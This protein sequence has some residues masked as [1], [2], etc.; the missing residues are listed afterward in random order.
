MKP[1]MV[2]CV[3]TYLTVAACDAARRLR[4]GANTPGSLHDLNTMGELGSAQ[5]E[6][7]QQALLRTGSRAT[8]ATNTTDNSSMPSLPGPSMMMGGR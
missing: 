3:T 1:P 4:A 6:A 5:R 2:W 7:L 8:S